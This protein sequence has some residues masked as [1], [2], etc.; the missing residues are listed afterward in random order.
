VDG[1]RQRR[2]QVLGDLA[3]RLGKLEHDPPLTPR[4]V[5]PCPPEARGRATR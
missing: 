3:A 4:Q 5:G 2:E 1:Q